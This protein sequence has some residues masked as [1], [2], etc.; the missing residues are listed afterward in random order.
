[1]AK[2]EDQENC[3]I[4]LDLLNVCLEKA[5]MQTA[6]INNMMVISH[7]FKD[8]DSYRQIRPTF[9]ESVAK[10]ST[11]EPVYVFNAGVMAAQEV[12]LE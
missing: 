11:I 12:T 3:Q 1:M 4:T 8:D 2:T 6:T 5:G 9:E 10:E 7:G